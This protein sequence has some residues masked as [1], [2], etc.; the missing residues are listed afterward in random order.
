MCLL[1]LAGSLSAVGGG[2]GMG[3]LR[4]AGLLLGLRPLGA[5][6][7]NPP[8]PQRP[9]CDADLEASLRQVGSQ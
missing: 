9:P 3:R 2:A 1:R 7:E 4:A 5:H 8:L 6:G